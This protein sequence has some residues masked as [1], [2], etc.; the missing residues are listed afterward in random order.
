MY[1]DDDD[2]DDDKQVWSGYNKPNSEQLM[3]QI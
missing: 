1:Y 3:Y 2:D